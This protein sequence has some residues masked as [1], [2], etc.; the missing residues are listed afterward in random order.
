MFRFHSSSG[1]SH[2]FDQYV[3]EEEYDSQLMGRNG[4]EAPR[5][6]NTDAVDVD[7]ISRSVPA[8]H[9]ERERL[10][11]ELVASERRLQNDL[12]AAGLL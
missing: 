7:E 4:G 2:I 6:P 8:D 5:S 9:P 1:N 3:F 11:A 12:R 10:I